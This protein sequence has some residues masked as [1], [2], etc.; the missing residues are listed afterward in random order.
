MFKG[1]I[2]PPITSSKEGYSIKLSIFLEL[3][4]DATSIP[5]MIKIVLGFLNTSIKPIVRPPLKL[6]AE[7][8][9]EKL[10]R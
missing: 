2:D 10:K 4:D 9:L 1:I 6:K 3:Q 5:S 7:R 8:V